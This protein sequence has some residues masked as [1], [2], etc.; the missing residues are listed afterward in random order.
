MNTQSKWMAFGLLI[1]GFILVNF[2]GSFMPGQVDFT[3]ENLYTLS[4]GSK[5]LLKKIEDPVQVNLYFSRSVEHPIVQIK[6]YAKRAEGLLKQYQRASGGTIEVNVID[7][8]PDTKEEED[9]TRAGLTPQQLPNGEAFFLGIMVSQVDREE[10]LPFLDPRRE[11]LL[12][13]DISQALYKV[14]NTNKPK[15]GIIAGLEVFGSAPPSMPG[16]PPQMSQG[17]EK[18]IF[19]GEL[20]NFFDVQNIDTSEEELPTDLDVLFVIHPQELSDILLYHIDQFLLSGKSVI[21]A[22]DPLSRF[23]MMN[24]QQQQNPMMMMNQ[25]NSSDLGKLFGAYGIKYDSTKVVGDFEYATNVSGGRSSAP[26]LMPTWITLTRIDSELPPVAELDNVFL[27][28]PGS[29]SL[30]DEED[31]SLTFTPILQGS[32][33]SDS[34]AASSLRFMQPDAIANRMNADGKVKTYAALIQGKFTS[35]FPNGKP[36]APKRDDEEEEK[37]S[38]ETEKAEPDNSLKESATESKLIVIADTDFLADRFSVQRINLLGM[39]AIRPINDNLSLTSNLIEFS[40]GSDDLLSIRGK[41]TT[42]RDFD[43]VKQLQ[44]KAQ[45]EFQQQEEVINQSLTDIRNQLS[46]LQGQKKED[47]VLVANAELR[48]SIQAMKEQE[49]DMLRQRR[50]I[51]K[52]L[53]EDIELLDNTLAILNLTVS[54]ALIICFALIFF[55]KRS[56]S[57]E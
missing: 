50:E 38:K 55:S 2:I 51:R 30:K 37:E 11:A 18:W 20:E 41:G 48:K 6:N 40:S 13:Y 16:M 54:P 47:G 43:K 14:G 3:E 21:A 29:L 46:E 19:L 42:S 15:L 9:A 10:T 35:A 7:P 53:R 26:M 39:N 4:K 12:E 56:K 57:K 17:G 1:I 52:K 36:E 24:S 34:I 31:S 44:I 49:A 27:G 45:K 33:R 22:V 32:E 8:R 5:S 25:S 28:D 23:Q